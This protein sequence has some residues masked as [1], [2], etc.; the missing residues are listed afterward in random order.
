MIGKL[1]GVV[2]VHLFVPCLLITSHQLFFEAS[3]A[4]VVT[5]IVVVCVLDWD[6]SDQL[7]THNGKEATTGAPFELKNDGRKNSLDSR[8]G[9]PRSFEER[10]PFELAARCAQL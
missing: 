9:G 10:R 5:L 6:I 4:P 1:I 7:T 2:D 3:P 8:G